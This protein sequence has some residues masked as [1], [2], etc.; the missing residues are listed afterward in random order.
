[1]HHHFS[2][3]LIQS[4]T[5]VHKI[6]KWSA[7]DRQDY[8]ISANVFCLIEAEYDLRFG[9]A[10]RHF[11]ISLTLKILRYLDK[12]NIFFLIILLVVL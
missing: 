4:I 7:R 10:R 3:S 1:M 8:D 11:K 5:Q 2:A 6:K 9:T 12:V